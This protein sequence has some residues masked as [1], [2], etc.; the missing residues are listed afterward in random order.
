MKVRSK[1]FRFIGLLLGIGAISAIPVSR[2]DYFEINKQLEIFTDLYREINLF[3]VDEQQPS[4]LMDKA[5]IS[6]L[7]SLDPYTNYIPETYVED[8]RAQNTGQYAG[9]GAGIRHKSEYPVISSIHQGLAADKAGFLI[10]DVLLKVAGLDLKGLSIDDVSRLL[11]GAPGTRVEVVLKRGDKSLS[12][13]VKREEVRVPSVPHFTELAPGIGYIFLSQF[14]ERASNEVRQAFEELNKDGQLKG[15]IL[16]LRGNPGGLLGEAVN[17]SN[18]FI[19][20]GQEVVRTK[21][22]V[23]EADSRY[24]TQFNPLDRN[25]PLVVLINGSSASAS[26]IVAGVMQDLD[27]GVILG[28]RSFGKGL[29]QQTKPISYGAQV[30]LTIAKYYTPSGRCI[31]AIDYAERDELGRVKS[32]PDSLRNSFKTI[33]GRLVKDGGGI[34]PDRSIEEDEAPRIL[35]SLLQEDIIFDFANELQRKAPE[36]SL[37]PRTFLIS[38]QTF[39]SFKSFVAKNDF[40]YDTYTDDVIR[41]LKSMAA[42][43]SFDELLK[44]VETLQSTFDKLKSDDLDEHEKAIKQWLGGELV[45]RYAFDQGRVI[46]DLRFDPV[47]QQAIELLNDPQAY[48]SILKGAGK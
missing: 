6:M 21:G 39:D 41:E 45:M 24:T 40:K 3:Y 4:E 29:V 18:L 8:F 9:V 30:K 32:I 16:D 46:Y 25:I 13:M 31:Q 14:N 22:K 48:Q 42:E 38:D 15:L 2:T 36:D 5:I 7:S 11:K 44:E 47:S 33:S 1:L 34:D 10:G 12:K 17:V 23:K 28:Q 43:E 37:D 35:Y 26:E 27:R 19:D 20:K